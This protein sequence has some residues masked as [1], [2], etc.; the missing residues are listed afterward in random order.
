VKRSPGQKRFI[1]T[2]ESQICCNDKCC[3]SISHHDAKTHKDI[4]WRYSA[5]KPSSYV[6]IRKYWVLRQIRLLGGREY[7]KGL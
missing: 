2:V 1:S 6:V 3:F 4:G 7:L 5:R